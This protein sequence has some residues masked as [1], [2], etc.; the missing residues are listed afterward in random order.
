MSIAASEAALPAATPSTSGDVRRRAPAA[1]MAPPA[2]VTSSPTVS[3]SHHSRFGPVTASHARPAAP[4][5]PPP[6]LGP[7]N[8]LERTP[9]DERR[10]PRGDVVAALGEQH[11]AGVVELHRG[12]VPVMD[13]REA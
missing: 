6:A 8:R 5:H 10:K 1:S 7:G 9:R 3:T 4:P 2:T 12:G 11:G 13:E